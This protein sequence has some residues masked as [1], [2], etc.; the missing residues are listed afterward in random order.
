MVKSNVLIHF[1]QYIGFII[2][3]N[4]YNFEVEKT[5]FFSIIN[6]ALYYYKAFIS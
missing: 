2:Y 1:F 5:L 6:I 4:N 3:I